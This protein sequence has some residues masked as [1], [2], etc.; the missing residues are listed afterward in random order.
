MTI[1]LSIAVDG[2]VM[3]THSGQGSERIAQLFGT[4]TLPLPWTFDMIPPADIV[5]HAARILD[6][7][8]TNNPSDYVRWADGTTSRMYSRYSSAS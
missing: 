6:T 3:A 8:R 4:L 7:L 5:R 2:S 1:T